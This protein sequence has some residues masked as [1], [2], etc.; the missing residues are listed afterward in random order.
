MTTMILLQLTSNHPNVAV[1]DRE[2]H[3]AMRGQQ[4]C[5]ECKSI[6][7]RRYPQPWHVV[8]AEHPGHC[9]E[10]PVSECGGSIFHVRFIEMIRHELAGYVFGTCEEAG[11]GRIDECVT[12]Y[13]KDIL[14]PRGNEKSEYSICGTCGSIHF[15]WWRSEKTQYVLRCYLS[16]AAVYQDASGWLYLREDL[17]MS[18]DLSEWPDAG[19][20]PI[21]VRD[22][23]LDG[24]RLPIDPPDAPW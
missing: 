8:L 23:P 6:D 10:A 12:C 16:D 24:R 9:I 1:S 5:A 20:R 4:V 17:A 19:W 14:V 2:W 11:A 15:H 22:T 7:R 21:E 18:L 13:H 3:W